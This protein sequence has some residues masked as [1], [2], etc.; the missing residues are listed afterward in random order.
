MSKSFGPHVALIV[1]SIAA[2]ER[3]QPDTLHLFMED[4]I[5]QDAIL[6]RLQVIGEHLARMRQIDE[7]HFDHIASPSWYQIIGL[8]NIISHGYESIDPTRIWTYLQE[9]L[10]LLREQLMAIDQFPTT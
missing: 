4:D 1:E 9:S 7:K 2:I 3:Y 8:R 10:G 6:M 5:V